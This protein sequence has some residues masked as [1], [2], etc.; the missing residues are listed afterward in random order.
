M[1]QLNQTEE[2]QKQK[3]RK[4]LYEKSKN[5]ECLVC[6]KTIYPS[7]DFEAV[8]TKRKNILLIHNS[9]I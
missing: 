8:K 4:T 6:G 7:D 9:C 5:K 3:T 2:I 1:E